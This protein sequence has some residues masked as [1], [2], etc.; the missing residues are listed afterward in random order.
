MCADTENYCIV[1]GQRAQVVA[2]FFTKHEHYLVTN[3]KTRII[4]YHICN[5][6][7]SKNGAVIIVEEILRISENTN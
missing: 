6:C 2:A 4:F 7:R 3:N 5:K 1:C